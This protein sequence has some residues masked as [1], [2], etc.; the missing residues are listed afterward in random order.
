MSQRFG[1]QLAH[2]TVGHM[3][4]A[5]T[6]CKLAM[7]ESDPKLRGGSSVSPN[8]RKKFYFKASNHRNTFVKYNSPIESQLKIET[9]GCRKAT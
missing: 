7:Y 6:G 4:E 1:G 9:N 3:L 8:V 2:R 5:R